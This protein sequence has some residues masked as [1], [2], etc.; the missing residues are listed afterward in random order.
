MLKGPKACCNISAVRSK[1]VLAARRK[2]Q[3]T[4]ILLRSSNGVRRPRAAFSL[5]A[6]HAGRTATDITKV[7][8]LDVLRRTKRRFSL[9]WSL[10]LVFRKTIEDDR[11]RS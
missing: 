4:R 10:A 5:L 6:L 11:G 3:R 8:A 9:E 1:P 7:H 2:V